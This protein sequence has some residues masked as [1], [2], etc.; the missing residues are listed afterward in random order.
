VVALAPG[1]GRAA[2]NV[3]GRGE[4]TVAGQRIV[5]TAIYR[6]H[7]SAPEALPPLADGAK[8]YHFTPCRDADILI[9]GN[10]LIVNQREI[11]PLHAG[12][13]VIVDHGK[14][15]VKPATQAASGR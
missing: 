11:G 9:R 1:C 15:S 13:E 12:D 2:D 3:L 4:A 8:V 6:L 5:G 7:V 14:V 10:A